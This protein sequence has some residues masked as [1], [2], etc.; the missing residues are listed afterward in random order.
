M[1]PKTRLS[2]VWMLCAGVLSLAVLGPI[3][4]FV[5]P[6]ELLAGGDI[7]YPM[8]S[9]ADGVVVLRIATDRTGIVTA[10]GVVHGVASP[11]S[12]AIA[13][14]QSW[15]FQAASREDGPAAAAMTVAIVFRP[16]VVQAP[17]P[18]FEAVRPVMESGFK[19]AGI[20]AASYPE[21]PMNS[22]ASG[23]VV[24]QVPVDETGRAGAAEKI[25]GV[26][27]LTA[28]AKRAVRAWRFEAAN[29]NGKP[30][31]S[32]VAI[33]FVFRLPLT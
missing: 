4:A 31:A 9:V 27:P 16:A 12:P 7:A 3:G 22:I 15:K 8:A 17:P 2:L 1:S 14:V 20:R 5:K 28:Y 10:T 18:A 25:L 30:V 19:P 32:K 29:L 24:L 33:A 23:T 6:P 13:A 11:T 21:Y 26:A